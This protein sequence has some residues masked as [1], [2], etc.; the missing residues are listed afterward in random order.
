MRKCVLFVV[1]LSLSAIAYESMEMHLMVNPG[2][3]EFHKIT[4]PLDPDKLEYD[5]VDLGVRSAVVFGMTPPGTPSIG[6]VGRSVLLPPGATIT[7]IK[8]VSSRSVEIQ[9][10]YNLY[11][12]QKEVAFSNPNPK[13]NKPNKAVYNSIEPFPGKLVRLNATSSLSGYRIG[14][15][16]VYPLQYIPAE[17]RLILY[18]DIV[19]EIQ[20][21]SNRVPV[22][23]MTEEQIRIFSRS[24]R[25]MVCNPEDLIRFTPPL[26]I[27]YRASG[28]LPA[29]T[30]EYV[31]IAPAADTA[32][33]D[34]LLYWK[35]KK[36]IKNPKTVALEWI[37]SQYPVSGDTN[38]IAQFVADAETT[39]GTMYFLMSGDPY[40]PSAGEILP[41][42]QMRADYTS[43][44]PISD[45]YYAETD[46]YLDGT[47]PGDPG[48]A[49][50]ED[51]MVSRIPVDNHTDIQTFVK[52]T[53]RHEKDPVFEDMNPGYNNPVM[54]IPVY[55]LWSD[56]T[57][58][59]PAD[60]IAV[61]TPSPWVDSIRYS[62]NTH[63][64][65]QLNAMCQSGIRY[66][67]FIGH[68]SETSWTGNAASDV[69]GFTNFPNTPILSQ[70][71]C[72][73]NKMDHTADCY[74]EAY[75]NN[76]NGGV[77]ALQGN[78]R[79]GLGSRSGAWDAENE[80]RSSG[81]CTDFYRYQW[82]WGSDRHFQEAW[83]HARNYVT[84]NYIAGHSDDAAVWSRESSNT[85]GDPELPL[86]PTGDSIVSLMGVHNST[87]PIGAYSFTVTVTAS[88]SP[89]DSTRVC[90]WCKSE[91]SMWVRGWT[92]ASGQVTLHPNPSVVGDTMWVTATKPNYK[93]YEGSAVVI[94]V[95]RPYPI[96]NHSEI[97]S[98][99]DTLIN[100]GESTSAE[101]WTKNIGEQGAQSVYGILSISDPYITVTQDS[102]Y[103]GNIPAGDSVGGSPAYA[104]D[105]SINA[106][107]LYVLSFDFTTHDIYDSIVVSHPSY[108]VYAPELAYESD[109]IDDSPGNNDGIWD[110]GEQINL[111]VSIKNSGHLD[112]SDVSATLLSSDS[113]I[114]INSGNSNYGN[115]AQAT[116]ENNAS[117]PFIV[118]SDASTPQGHPVSFDI[119]FTYNGGMVD[120]VSY[121]GRVGIEGVDWANHDI[122]NTVL[123]VTRQGSIGYMS[124]MSGGVG[125]K[126]PSTGSNGLY[127]GSFACGTDINWV[128]DRFFNAPTG[129]KAD[130]VTTSSPDGLLRMGVSGYSEQNSIAI[131][132][133]SGNPTSKGLLVEQIGWSWSNPGGDDFVIL[134][135]IIKNTSSSPI[136]GLYSGIFLDLDINGS[137]DIGGVDTNRSLAFMVPSGGG[138]YYGLRVLEDSSAIKRRVSLQYNQDDVYPWSGMPDSLM[139]LFMDGSKYRDTSTTA[140]DYGVNASTGPYDISPGD[141]VIVAFTLVGGSNLSELQENSDTAFNYY[142]QY[143]AGIGEKV[144]LPDVYSMKMSAVT[145]NNGFD[146]RYSLPERALVSFSIY[147]CIGREIKHLAEKKEAGWYSRRVD[148]NDS[149]A[150]I[151]F[152][153]MSAKGKQFTQKAVLIR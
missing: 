107:D 74:C 130:W 144:E 52:K 152:I 42:A 33:F 34:S 49:E 96:Y 59:I 126:Y 108:I 118:T 117:N 27:S 140:A 17:G 79:Y 139:F 128:S 21:E 15:Y 101:I 113:Y 45:R 10:E 37:Y 11:P 30:V 99:T 18:T 94:S 135:Y 102:A 22:Q 16:M 143:Y 48:A 127:V 129:E 141:S 58:D 53:L 90:L 95:N 136:N 13:F 38:K 23:R 110:P 89:V 122:G 60:T 1:L 3:L 134:K 103:F 55:Q 119:A 80:S 106:P 131:F 69:S 81:L 93:P 114:T 73:T 31:V 14:G 54:Y 57:G 109:S 84:S 64:T 2:N 111:I 146:I 63:T 19:L 85:L 97:I 51:V 148:M 43:D 61:Q 36:G 91:A 87:I 88:G 120:T 123:T 125:W 6:G 115:I 142:W 65:A 40:D 86:Y 24:V 4:D 68:G 56:W 121:D 78:T 105:V 7:D 39:W 151:Y 76:P 66:H 70:I 149:P 20:Y 47:E 153:R 72:L 35:E 147:D 12:V 5:I 26:K 29:D 145:L 150:G 75:I 8:V 104:F 83:L 137:S 124:A 9:G 67:H 46:L 25:E 44:P 92:N 82:V 32:E 98:G 28:R 138:S 116:Q 41:M 77:V 50:L 133:D 100:P 62:T 71:C 112:A 132:D